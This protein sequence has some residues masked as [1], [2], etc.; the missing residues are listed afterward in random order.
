M[1]GDTPVAITDLKQ[2]VVGNAI[3]LTT[4]LKLIGCPGFKNLH[5]E[6]D[7]S[8]LAPETIA[9]EGI[10][11]VGKSTLAAAMFK[12][13]G[14]R[15]LAEQIPPALL[16]G[17]NAKPKETAFALQATITAL[18]ADLGQRLDSRTPVGQFMYPF[19]KDD[20]AV[21]SG[22]TSTGRRRQIWDRSQLGDL[23]FAFANYILG[24]MS[25]DE[26][27]IICQM[28]TRN[29]Q[30]NARDFIGVLEQLPC[31]QTSK[32][33]QADSTVDT[34]VF[35]VDQPDRCLARAKG[36]STGEDSLRLWYFELLEDIHLAV[37]L[38]VLNNQERLLGNRR[39]MVLTHDQ[40]HDNA[41]FFLQRLKE[42]RESDGTVELSPETVPES[43]VEQFIEPERREVAA[44]GGFVREFERTDC[45]VRVADK[46]TTERLLEDVHEERRGNEAVFFLTIADEASYLTETAAVCRTTEQLAKLGLFVYSR[47]HKDTLY[48]LLSKGQKI[49]LT[50]AQ[51]TGPVESLPTE[52]KT[53]PKSS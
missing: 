30:V 43:L 39:V 29:S 16:R 34:F 24:N 35:I 18:R 13:H 33:F 32:N 11:G 51:V 44:G 15:V 20:V 49:K 9:F 31:F 4:A 27:Q 6:I 28:A 46:E 12:E 25:L 2:L 41:A 48:E 5:V 45:F 21:A 22:L 38:H 10:I 36:R 17:F 47:E 52:V 14:M 50:F 8:W 53:E 40:I 26:F 1:S 7:S 3:A 23:T 19:G 42:G 37:L